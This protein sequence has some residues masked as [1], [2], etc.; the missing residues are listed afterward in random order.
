MII[1]PHCKREN[2]EQRALC[3][4]CGGSL[5]KTPITAAHA[6]EEANLS[7]EPPSPDDDHYTVQLA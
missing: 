1:C 3:A 5:Q 7:T 2:E 6:A 4:H